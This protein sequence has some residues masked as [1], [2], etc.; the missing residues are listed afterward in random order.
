MPKRINKPQ[1]VRQ[2]IG[3]QINHLRE[4]ENVDKTEIDRAR[5]IGYLS[6]VALTAIRDGELEERVRAIEKQMEDKGHE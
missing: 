4:A 1:H 2:V 3:E 5:A 6:S